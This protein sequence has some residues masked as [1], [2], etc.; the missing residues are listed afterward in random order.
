MPT[1]RLIKLNL[2]TGSMDQVALLDTSAGAGDAGKAI[3]LDS[4]GKLNLNMM[5][6]GVGPELQNI[7]T[8]EDLAAGDW[9]NVY[10]D[11]GTP[12]ARKADATNGLKRAHGFVKTSVTAPAAVDV[13]FD[14]ANNVLTGLTVGARYF[15]SEATPGGG[16]TTPPATAG[17]LVQYL[18][19]ALNATTIAFRPTDGIVV[20]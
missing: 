17:N 8:S 12:T 18:G 7:V 6:T 1:D 13:Y 2:T 16:V 19:T 10:D 3:A 15:L 14:G 4:T 5:P 11:A 20:A 9:V